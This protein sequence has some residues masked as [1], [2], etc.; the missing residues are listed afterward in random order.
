MTGQESIYIV[1]D[2]L[3]VVD[4]LRYLLA[5]LQSPIEA[6]DRAEAFLA[7]VP[8]SASGC[9]IADL[10]LPGL[11]GLELLRQM[12]ERG[13]ALSVVMMTGYADVPMTTQAM[14]LGAIDVLEKPCPP[15]QILDTVQT[16]LSTSSGQTGPS[17][18]ARF[19]ER[20]LRLGEDELSVL[21]GLVL[22]RT[23]QQIAE[24][25]DV[26][27]RTVQSRRASLFAKMGVTNRSELVADALSVGWI[28]KVG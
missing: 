21:N 14:K 7:K 5:R 12:R 2:D 3:A 19:E 4:S 22:G 15:Q 1:D 18:R 26:S 9:L 16:V 27:L 25:M 20:V 23:N 24:A 13:Y 11:S 6:F 17:N 28:P 10:R 8:A